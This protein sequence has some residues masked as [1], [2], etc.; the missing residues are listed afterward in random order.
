MQEKRAKTRKLMTVDAMLADAAAT[1]WHPVVLLD[2]S[3]IGAAFA[4]AQL[5]EDGAS[6]MLRFCLPGSARRHEALVCIVHS[7]VTGV[8]SGYR[9]GA[10][11]VAVGADSAACIAAFTQGEADGDA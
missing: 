7:S 8:P 6:H 4:S 5:P 10:K 9:V 11:F 2:I 1:V 3:P